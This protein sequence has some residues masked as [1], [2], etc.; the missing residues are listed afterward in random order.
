MAES[1][2]WL[3]PSMLL[4]RDL[5]RSMGPIPGFND[6]ETSSAILRDATAA[7]VR[8][9]VGDDYGTALLPHG[10][11]SRELSCYVNDAGIPVR[12]VLRWATRNGAQFL[13]QD[14]Q[15]GLLRGGAPA[16]LIVVD[17]DPFDDVT[18]LEDAA[19]VLAVVQAGILVKD[20]LVASSD[21]ELVS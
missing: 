20:R 12:D 16:D 14:E 4:G 3:V 8:I 17:G 6:F 1:G 11:Y 18:V 5:V 9:V 15:L 19:N 13:D 10:T 7:G 21:K 2:T